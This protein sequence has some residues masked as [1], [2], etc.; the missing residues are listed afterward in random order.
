MHDLGATFGGSLRLRHN[1]LP[2]GSQD[3]FILHMSLWKYWLA[4]KPLKKNNCLREPHATFT[5]VFFFRTLAGLVAMLCRWE[6][7]E[8]NNTLWSLDP[9]PPWRRNISINWITRETLNLHAGQFHVLPGMRGTR[10]LK[11]ILWCNGFCNLP[12]K[13]NMES[14]V[15]SC[16]K[17]NKESV[18]NHH[19]V[20]ES[21][22]L[23]AAGS[24]NTLP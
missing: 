2:N 1:H 9:D 13:S 3:L 10:S 18:E 19:A 20:K 11:I 4:P 15:E 17:T 21:E 5:E 16:K 24:F 12:R 8:L 23:L 22:A 7:Q 6:P 14:R